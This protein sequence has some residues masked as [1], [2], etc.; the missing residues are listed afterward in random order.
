[1]DGAL[2]LCVAYRALKHLTIPN[3]YPLPLISELLNKTRGRKWF[4]GLDLKNEYNLI[5][6][7]AGDEWK[8][9]ICTKQGLFEYTVMPFG[10]TNGPVSF[11]EMMYVIFEDIEGSI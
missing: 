2:R 4:T 5:G 3:K 1:M 8:I 9:G 7:V 10:L 6:I 11:Q